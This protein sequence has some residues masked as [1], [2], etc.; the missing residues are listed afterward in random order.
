MADA[1]RLNP[2]ASSA[3]AFRGYLY[4]KLQQ[5]ERAIADLRRAIQIDPGNAS[6]RNNLRAIGA[7]P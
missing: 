3:Y 7:T 1:I 2:E 5:R 6:A 4:I